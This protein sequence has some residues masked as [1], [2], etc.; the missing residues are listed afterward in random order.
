MPGVA[1]VLMARWLLKTEPSTFSIDDLERK[2]VAPWDGVRSF[3][4]RNHLRAMREGDLAL[5]YHSSVEPPGAVGVCRV[6]REAYPDHTAWDPRSP[7]FDPRST[8]ERPRWYMPD[9][10]F[11]ERFARM[12]TIGEMRATPGLEPMALLRRGQRLSVQPVTDEEWELV[13][14]LGRRG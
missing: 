3:Q 8:P 2:G 14:A 10:A 12:V 11:V 13:C 1:C 6:A 7:S 9:V 4:A 5:F